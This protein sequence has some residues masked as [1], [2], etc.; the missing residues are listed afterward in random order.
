MLN[1]LQPARFYFS[2]LLN[3]HEDPN[4][5]LLKLRGMLGTLT[6]LTRSVEEELKV[7]EKELLPEI[8]GKGIQSLPFEISA[9]LLV[10]LREDDDRAE[11]HL[12]CLC[13]SEGLGDKDFP[14]LETLDIDYAAD[15]SV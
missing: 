13:F 11:L 3:I 12:T 14:A 7:A 8:Y 10:L 1:S 6:R 2:H 4:T 5:V 9:R 15:A